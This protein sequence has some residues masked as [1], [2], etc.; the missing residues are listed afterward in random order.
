[1][2][3]LVTLTP[4]GNPQTSNDFML[5]PLPNDGPL[6][7][8]CTKLSMGTNLT[9]VAECTTAM[10]VKL[11]AEGASS[12]STELVLTFGDQPAPFPLLAVTNNNTII[13][14]HGIKQLVIL[15]GQ[16]HP[17]K[18]H[19]IG[20]LGDT[21]LGYGVPPIVKL[22][23]KDFDD[24]KPWFHLEMDTIQKAQEQHQQVL[25]PV[26]E[27]SAMVQTPKLIPVPLFL[28][29]FFINGRK[30][31]TAINTLH[32]YQHQFLN[33]ATLEL[34]QNTRFTCISFLQQLGM[35]P[36]K[37][38]QHNHPPANWQYKWKLFPLTQSLHTG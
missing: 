30:P 4:N 21:T 19:I 18:G 2:T 32:S 34:A 24:A 29:P 27:G 7:Q 8:T 16:T 10:Y 25:P 13:V 28:M 36:C 1:M 33:N 22:D 20:F 31:R 14:L 38:Q 5:P 12:T 35:T 9:M 11:L 26:P 17:N 37:I 3:T 15:Y 6:T 23:T